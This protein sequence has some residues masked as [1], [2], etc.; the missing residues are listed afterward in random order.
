MIGKKA[1]WEE[2]Y[3]AKT[4][5][6]LSWFQEH[7]ETSVRFIRGLNLEKTATII[8]VGGG[9]STLVDDLLVD[10]FENIAVLDLSSA[11]L[12]SAKNR[13]KRQSK[14]V[15][16]LEGDVRTFDFPEDHYDVW[17]DRAVF[18]FL[19]HPEDRAAYMKN[20]AH[21]LKQNGS[22][23]IS[24]FAEGGPQRCSGLP[25]M[26][27]SVE[28]LSAEFGDAFLLKDYLI[29]DHVTPFSTKQKFVYCHFVKRNQR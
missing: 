11:A 16:W 28:T 25:V 7:A 21:S 4:A 1:Y 17:H 19:T 10:K 8:D 15:K 12:E 13:T 3:S 20:L 18:H 6:A 24:T 2:V 5:D 29:E 9:A 23:I 27:Y 22:V 14:K 26:R